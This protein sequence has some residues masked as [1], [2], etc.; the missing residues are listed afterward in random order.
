MRK[1]VVEWASEAWGEH[2]DWEE[3]EFTKLEDA[4]AEVLRQV[5]YG[6]A[7]RMYIKEV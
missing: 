7:V 4:E 5:G 1:Y 6:N 3:K 2:K